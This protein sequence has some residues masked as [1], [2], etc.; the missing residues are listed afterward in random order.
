MG[1]S[2]GLIIGD[3]MLA[4]TTNILTSITLCYMDIIANLLGHKPFE[5]HP[6]SFT[7]RTAFFEIESKKPKGKKRK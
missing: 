4:T 2:L 3:K 5:R 1:R 6:L 7:D